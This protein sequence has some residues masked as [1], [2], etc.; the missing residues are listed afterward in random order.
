MSDNKLNPD[1]GSTNSAVAAF[2]NVFT[3]SAN[4]IHCP[5]C[6]DS[7]VHFE[8]ISKIDGEDSYKSG[9]GNRGD[10]ISIICWCEGCSAKF[11]I[12]LGFHKGNTHLAVRIG[13]DEFVPISLD[14]I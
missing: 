14:G 2:T 5:I 10:L 6:N 12:C 3:D 1:R 13:V 11:D 4:I 7:Y 8:N 9:A